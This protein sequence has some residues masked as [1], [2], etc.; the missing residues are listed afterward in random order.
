MKATK[1]KRVGTGGRAEA[2]RQAE[3]ALMLSGDKSQ[4]AET[5]NEREAESLWIGAD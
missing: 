4:L 1:L 3:K 5:F 2:I